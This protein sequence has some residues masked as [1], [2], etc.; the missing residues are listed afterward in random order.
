MEFELLYGTG[1][2][3]FKI[4]DKV[5][6][7]TISPTYT[8]PLPNPNTALKQALQRPTG[9]VALSGRAKAGDRVGI[10]FN[11]ITR[12]TP[13]ATII[14]AILEELSHISRENI[15]LYNALGTHRPNTD[16][17]LRSIL[18]PELVDN[19]R[20]VQNNSFDQ[21]TQ[22]YRGK[23]KRGHP[24]W[25]NKDLLE[26]DLL[27]LTGFI[28]PHLFAGFS[29]GCKAVMPGMAGLWTIMHNHGFDMVGDP[30]AI[31]GEMEKNPL[32]QEIREIVAA[33]PNTFLVNVAMNGDQEITGVFAGDL[34]QA[35]EKGIEFVRETAMAGV[36]EPFDIVISCNSGYPLDQNLYQAVKG[37]S[38]AAQIVRPGGAIVVASECRD[39]IPDHGLFG[40]MLYEAESVDAL[41]EMVGR[42][43][44]HKLDQWGIQV[45]ALIL[46]KARVYVY[47][48]YLDRETVESRL[49]EYSDNLERTIE[50]LLDV[51]GKEARIGVLPEGPLTI[52]YVKGPEGTI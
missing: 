22:V 19:F 43:G 6:V 45:T 41:L 20:I 15:T 9:S 30:N 7:E 52:P 29:G 5:Q 44:F 33:L 31:W 14:T 24:I 10:I 3:K 37:M 12:A 38:A 36:D 27:L 16:A 8:T 4:S 32:Q 46:K 25:L 39:G 1:K 48:D 50:K 49:L 21:E 51:Y 17:E 40:K 2:L 42:P 35:H 13:N 34:I 47:S 26:N 23:T 28:E 11:D 18:S